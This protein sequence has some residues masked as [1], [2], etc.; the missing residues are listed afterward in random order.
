MKNA[1]RA[2]SAAKLGIALLVQRNSALDVFLG[3][4][5]SQERTK[6]LC[7]D[8]TVSIFPIIL[9]NNHLANPLPSSPIRA[10][11]VIRG[12]ILLFSP[13]APGQEAKIPTTFRHAQA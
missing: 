13:S 7:N 6:K 3:S 1:N 11:R 9:P 4:D 10:L 5:A 2:V 12:E 8:A